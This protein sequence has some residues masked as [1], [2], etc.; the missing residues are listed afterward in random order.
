MV[1]KKIFKILKHAFRL[2]RKPHRKRKGHHRY[3]KSRKKVSKRHL[4]THRRRKENAA[5]LPPPPRAGSVHL[6]PTAEDGGALTGA[7]P[8][9]AGVVTLSLALEMPAGGAGEQPIYC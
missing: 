5:P 1:F 6:A 9:G 7:A 3:K 4:R 2:R 8:G